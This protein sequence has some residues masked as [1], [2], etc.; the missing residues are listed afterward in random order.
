MRAAWSLL[1]DLGTKFAIP[2]FR[3]VP[4]LSVFAFFLDLHTP[5]MHVDNLVE[6][7]LHR[8]SSSVRKADNLRRFNK[9]SHEGLAV[10]DMS[11]CAKALS[12]LL[13]DS[14][15]LGQSKQGLR[16]WVQ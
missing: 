12:G 1:L 5:S 16:Y 9:Y 6:F 15:Q 13:V 2:A 8:V 3:S 10:N 4:V 7:L 14:C 11:S